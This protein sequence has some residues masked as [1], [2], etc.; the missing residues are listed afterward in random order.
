MRRLTAVRTAAIV[1][2]FAVAVASAPASAVVPEGGDTDVFAR[3]HQRLSAAP[4]VPWTIEGD[5]VVPALPDID[6]ILDALAPADAAAPGAYPSLAA[7][8]I[9]VESANSGSLLS[10]FVGANLDDVAGV[11]GLSPFTLSRLDTSSVSAFDSGLL[12]AGG[13]LS[14]GSLDDLMAQLGGP[15]SGVD[16]MSAASASTFARQLWQLNLPQ[17]PSAPMPQVDLAAAG[18]GLLT[19]R[20]LA[21]FATDFPDVFATASSSGLGTEEHRQAWSAS[22]LRAYQSSQ[23]DLTTALPSSCM[24]GMLAIAASGQPGSAAPFGNCGSDCQAAGMYLNNQ[25][26]GLWQPSAFAS[27]PVDDGVL[28]Q[29]E[30]ARLPGW[31]RDGITAE[32]PATTTASTLNGSLQGA[33]ATADPAAGAVRRVLPGVFD[34]L[35]Q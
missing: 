6:H 31:L 18:F 30:L 20:S 16:Q 25:M 13:G 3:L 15:V 19:N 8:L 11:T 9:G 10:Q 35:G 33:C 1:A 23:R 21:A 5:L 2:A 24:A 27:Q 17:M 7:A 34:A 4:G 26:L 14:L 12:S 32:L 22:M 28:N 29:S